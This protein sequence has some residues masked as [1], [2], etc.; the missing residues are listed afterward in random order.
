MPLS[1]TDLLERQLRQFVVALLDLRDLRI[2]EID[3]EGDDLDALVERLLHDVAERF[4]QAVVDDDALDAEIDRLQ[5]LLALL[6]GILA[7]GEDAQIDAERLGLRFGAGLIG[8]EEIAGGNVADQRHLDAALVEGRRRAG[9][10]VGLGAPA[11]EDEGNDGGG[12]PR[13]VQ[14]DFMVVF[15]LS[16]SETRRPTGCE[17]LRRRVY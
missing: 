11:D 17:S 4:R 15:L 12:L 1:L 2:V 3:V 8:L 6:G 7:A 13:A 14:K 16:R 9:D 5:D 10:A